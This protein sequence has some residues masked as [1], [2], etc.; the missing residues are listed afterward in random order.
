MI[1]DVTW[2]NKIYDWADRPSDE[3]NKLDFV[4]LV[5]LELVNVGWSFC[6]REIF[7]L[8][9]NDF[10]SVQGQNRIALGGEHFRMLMPNSN[11]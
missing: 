7:I 5:F 4:S 11:Q 10:D 1:V 9:M 8:T 2:N 3:R 6:P